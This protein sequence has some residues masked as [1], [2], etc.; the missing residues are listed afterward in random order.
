MIF[1]TFKKNELLKKLEN[2]NE[3]KRKTVHL[4]FV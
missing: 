1:M 4:K 3:K 2:K